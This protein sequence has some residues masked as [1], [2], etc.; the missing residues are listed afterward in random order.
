MKV[1]W[2][3]LKQDV[4]IHEHQLVRVRAHQVPPCPVGPDIALFL[5]HYAPAAPIWTAPGQISDGIVALRVYRVIG[6]HCVDLRGQLREQAIA[7]AALNGIWREIGVLR[8]E[9]KNFAAV[10][11]IKKAQGFPPLYGVTPGLVPCGYLHER[12]VW[13]LLFTPEMLGFCVMQ[14]NSQSI[15]SF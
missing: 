7:R 6:E 11:P 1:I 9:I 12:V 4:V 10:D 8:R 5:R 14:A 2:I 15:A 13:E 3:H